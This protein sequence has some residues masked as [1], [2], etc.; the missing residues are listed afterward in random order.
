MKDVRFKALHFFTCVLKC[1][2]QVPLSKKWGT[3]TPRTPVNYAYTPK[4]T[5]VPNF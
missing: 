3:G 2:V 5:K 1:G 4:M